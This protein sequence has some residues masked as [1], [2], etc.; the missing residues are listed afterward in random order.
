M[1]KN[2]GASK[3]YIP[4]GAGS[5]KIPGLKKL[6]A[7]NVLLELLIRDDG[8]SHLN[9]DETRTVL[10]EIQY[11]INKALRKIEPCAGSD[12]SRKKKAH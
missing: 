8:H 6:Q 3:P 9:C 12:P 4:K 7:A 2:G 1:C 5:M 11:L 10:S